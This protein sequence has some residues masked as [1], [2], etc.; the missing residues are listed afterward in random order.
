MLRVTTEA[1]SAIVGGCDSLTITPCGFDAHLADNVHHILRE[2]SH[3]DSV[4]DP[5]AGS[6]YVEALTNA[7]SAAAWTL[8]QAIEGGGGWATYQASGAADAALATSR[9][10][11]EQA[12]AERRRVLVGTNNYPEPAGA[13]AGRGRDA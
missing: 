3:L 1:L 9:T 12:V 10:S 2:E 11:K 8:F 7:L 6:S 5:G 4:Q 13:P